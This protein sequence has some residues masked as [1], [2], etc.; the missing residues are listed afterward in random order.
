MHNAVHIA[1]E[2]HFRI[3]FDPLVQA[4]SFFVKGQ[5]T[6]QRLHEGQ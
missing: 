2:T 1:I 6:V 4:V 5:L 3:I